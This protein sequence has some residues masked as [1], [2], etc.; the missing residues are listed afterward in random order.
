MINPPPP[1][2]TRLTELLGCDYPILQAGMGG[3]ARSELCAAVSA[4][5]GFGCIGMVKESPDLIGREIVAVRERTNRAFG[6]NIV[7]AITDPVLLEEQLDVCFRAGVKAMVFFWDVRPDIVERARA[8]GCMVL[9]QVG[10]VADAL[11]AERA[12]AD[13][14]IC[15]GVEAGGHVHGTVTSMVLLPQVVAAVKIPVAGAGGFGSGA[16]LVAALALGAEGVHCGTAFLATDESFAHDYHKQRVVDAKSEDTVYSDVFAIGWPPRSP[17]R[18]IENS[19][20]KAYADNLIGHGPN[21]FEL[22]VIAEFEDGPIHR[23]STW[24][25]LRGMAGDLEAQALYA[26]QVA[27]AIKRVRPA[28]EVVHEM[29]D[30]A[31]SRLARLAAVK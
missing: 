30:E 25:P 19:V 11:A 3:P 13:A 21:D 31:R 12:G 23:Y 8:A 24:S 5:G 22:D 2:H 18:T 6:V 1:L 10:N 20:T 14:I 27:G 16:S 28:A 4:A 17:V 29:V 26:G 15:Q 9:Y 7:P